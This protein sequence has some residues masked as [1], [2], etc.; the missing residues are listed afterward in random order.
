MQD[1]GPLG[2]YYWRVITGIDLSTGMTIGL[3]HIVSFLSLI[4]CIALIF[5]SMLIIRAR[6][7]AAEN[8]FMCVLLLAE[9][10]RVIANWYN[11]LPL[12]PEYL[13]AVQAYRVV[14]YFCGILCIM[15]YL[16]TVAFYPTKRT[17]FMT[18]DAIKNNLWWALP[19][20]SATLLALM[21]SSSGSLASTIGGTAH[22]DCT[23]LTDADYTDGLAPA[24]MSYSPGTEE[25]KGSCDNQ[26]APFSYFL[27]EAGTGL[28]TLLLI[29]PVFSATIA[30]FL[31]RSAW[32]DLRNQ[33]GQEDA[34]N[35]A[36]ALFIGFS[37]KAVL[38]GTLVLSI[39]FTTIKFGRFNLADSASIEDT[40]QLAIYY[41]CLYGFLFSILLTG[42]FEGF[43]FSY[44]I[45]KNDILGIDRRLRQTFS[46][47]SFA[48]V[49][50]ILMLIST[51]IM[52][53][54]SGFGWI[55]GVL[56]GLPLI[57]LR[58]PIYG[59]IDGFS[60]RIMPESLTGPQRSYLEAYETVAEDGVITDGE[61]KLLELQ[62]KNLG[63]SA[64]QVASLESLY[65]SHGLVE[66][67]LGNDESE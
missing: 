41:A 37:G 45:L 62:A 15:L 52:E 12:G 58:K 48:G 67:S 42:M 55:G 13:P 34:A 19:V 46:A 7:K 26:Y 57:L 25:I 36:R 29:I 6:P 17:R 11:L 33:E 10:W 53:S 40:T 50:A 16:S 43:M 65:D 59:V 31:M 63:L 9:A 20:I 8:R 60:S 4:T 54:I 5:L 22:V 30:V 24:T 28:G 35:E 64:T 56:I 38:K 44:A 66:E 2:A 1:V 21:I 23:G 32:K 47:A 61:R 49:G 51:E 14:W 18:K 3:T 27:P 39:I